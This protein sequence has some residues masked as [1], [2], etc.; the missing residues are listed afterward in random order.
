VT[1]ECYEALEYTSPEETLC[2]LASGEASR[3]VEAILGAALY[4][5][6]PD[7]VVSAAIALAAIPDVAVQRAAVLALTH[8]CARF[9]SLPRK[10]VTQ[11]LGRLDLSDPLLAGAVEDLVDDM[12]TFLD[13]PT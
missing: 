5:P 3:M 7:W 13:A 11:L 12:S 6:D 1:G 4:S 10:A 2:E 8:L 9:R